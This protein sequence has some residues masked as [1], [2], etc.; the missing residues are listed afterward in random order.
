[1]NPFAAALSAWNLS[2]NILCDHY[3]DMGRS[4]LEETE[5]VGCQDTN[6][7][8]PSH[9]LNDTNLSIQATNVVAQPVSVPVKLRSC[10]RSESSTVSSDAQ[11]KLYSGDDTHLLQ[12]DSHI[13]RS[14]RF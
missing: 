14:V 10:I 8:T 3:E 2:W 9:S 13:S 11:R 12:T 5:H 1:M 6:C 7:S 4:L